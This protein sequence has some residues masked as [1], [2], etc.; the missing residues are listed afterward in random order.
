MRISR[1]LEKAGLIVPDENTLPLAPT[2]TGADFPLPLDLLDTPPPAPAAEPAAASTAVAEGIAFDAVYAQ[3]GVREANFPAERLIKLLDGLKTM[4]TVA[5]KAVVSAMDAADETWEIGDVVADAQAKIA[6]LNAY[7]RTQE[8]AAQAV[9]ARTQAQ[10][11][12]AQTA[13]DAR[14]AEINEQIAQLQKTLEIAAA[15]HAQALAAL[16]AE[17]TGASEAAL[18]ERTRIGTEVQRLEALV[19]Q[20]G[21]P[22]SDTL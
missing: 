7:A 1:I 21:T 13:Y 4:D 22:T 9:S 16:Q 8:A 15:E 20:F 6:A 17:R 10:A 5:Q 19:T 2:E 3:A 11:G 18:R 12:S 14:R